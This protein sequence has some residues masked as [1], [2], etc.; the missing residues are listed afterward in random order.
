MRYCLHHPFYYINIKR[1]S[2]CLGDN[3]NFLKHYSAHYSWLQ[4]LDKIVDSNITYYFEKFV[5]LYHL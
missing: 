3:L 2:F 4:Y 5:K 1:Y